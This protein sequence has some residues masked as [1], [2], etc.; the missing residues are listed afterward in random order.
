MF[1]MKKKSVL[2]EKVLML[3]D[4]V[5][6]LVYFIFVYKIYFPRAKG[7]RIFTY[8]F[9]KKLSQQHLTVVQKLLSANYVLFKIS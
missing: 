9:K 2:F 3:Q 8:F 5:S 1:N 7:S 4:N 6:Y